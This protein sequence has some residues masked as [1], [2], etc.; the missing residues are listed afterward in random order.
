MSS[1]KLISPGMVAHTLNLSTQEQRQGDLY[2]IEARVEYIVNSKPV[3]A[4]Y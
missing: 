2:K 3:K 1:K 4:T